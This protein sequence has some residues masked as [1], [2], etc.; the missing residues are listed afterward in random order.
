MKALCSS[1]TCVVFLCS[2]EVNTD[3]RL[4]H[5]TRHSRKRTAATECDFQKR[6]KVFPEAKDDDVLQLSSEDDDAFKSDNVWLK[7]STVMLTME[8]KRVLTSGEWLNDQHIQAALTL[9]KED[10]DLLPVDGLQDPLLGENLSFQVCGSEMVQILH[11]GSSH[12][13]TISTVGANHPQ[14]FVYDSLYTSLPFKTKEKICS[15][16][17]CNEDEITLKYANVQVLRNDCWRSRL[18]SK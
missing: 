8:D 18:H 2:S 4:V 15:L 10:Q 3:E 11:S 9:M 16:I 13:I 6:S 14:V 17:C 5:T 1:C 7:T 12:W